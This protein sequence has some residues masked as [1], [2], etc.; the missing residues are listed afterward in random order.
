MWLRQINKI[1]AQSAVRLQRKS[2]WLAAVF[3]L[4]ASASALAAPEVD[5]P[6]RDAL[7]PAFVPGELLVKFRSEVRKQAAADY[8]EWFDISTRRTFA[9]NG[10]QHVKLPEGVGIEEALELYLEDP[11]VEHAEPNYIVY[12]DIAPP[13]DTHF[14]RLWGL[15][16]TG[17]NVDGTNGTD[18]ADIDALEAWDVTTG[19]SDII[20][21][22]V[23]SGVDINHPDLQA[24]IWANP[25][26]TP[27]NGIDDD[28]NGYIDDVSG[29]DFYIDDN[30]P[31]DASGHGTHVAG[32]IAAA[33]HNATGVTGVSWSAKIMALRFLDAWGIGTTANAIAA[34]EYATAMGADVINNSWGGG[35]YNQALKDAIDAADAVVVC[36]AG[37]S[38]ID[39]DSI[40]YYPSNY[41]SANIIAV[42]ASDQDDTLASF[43]NYGASSVDVAAPGTNIYSAAPGRETVWEDDFEDN[44]IGNWTTGGTNNTWDTTNE[45]AFAGT[46][47]LTDSP[48]VNYQINTNSWAYSPPID[49]SNHTAA[50][51]EFKMY[52]HAELGYDVLWVEASTNAVIWNAVNLQLPGD[53]NLYIGITGAVGSWASI[54]ADLEAYDDNNSVYVRFRLESDNTIN[55][56]GY[57]IDDVKVTAASSSYNGDEYTFK[58]GTSMATPHVAGLAALL[59]AHNPA[60]SIIQIKAAIEDSV[61]YKAALNNR[62]KADGRINAAAALAAPQ[63]SNVQVSTVSE[64]TAVITWTTDKP[65]DS[66][67]RYGTTSAA[68]GSYGNTATDA[69]LKTSHSITLSGLSQATDYY[70]RVGST[71]AY[72]NG[73]DNKTG[74]SNPTAED[75]F[76]TLDPDP[77]SIV[78]F[79]VINFA[80]DTITITYDEQNMQGAD[81]EDNYSFSPSMNF[82]SINPTDDDIADLGNSVFRLSMASIPA[83]QIFTLAVSNITDLAGNP[84][85]PAGIKIND[86]DNDSMA[87]DWESE[88]SLNKSINDSAADPD[89]DGYTNFQ[90][91]KARTNPRSAA[92][93]PFIIQDT[94]PNHNAG[95]T[96]T[97]RVPNN[98]DFAVLV[99][100]AHGIDTTDNT[101]VRFTI[102]DG[103]NTSY[104]RSLGDATVRFMKLTADPDDQVTRMWLMYDRSQEGGILTNFPYDSNV[105]IKVDCTDVMTNNMNQAAIDFNVETS[106]EH[107]DAQNSESVPDSSSVDGSDPDLGGA[108]DDGIK[109]DS[110]DLQGAKVIFDSSENQIPTLGPTDEIP[111]V[112]LTGVS[113]VAVP[114]NLQPPTVFD[115]PVKILIPCPGYADVS[116]LSVYY[117]NGSNWALASNAAGNVQPGGDG[118]MVPGSRVNHNETDPA[119]IEIQVYHFSGAQAGS[120]SGGGG[121]GG[122]GGGCFIETASHGSLIKHLLFYIVLNLAFI[123]LGIYG[124]K[125]IT[126]RK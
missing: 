5:R 17:Q 59:K 22:V 60:L 81:D 24:N 46:Y 47:S 23:D 49:L 96:D 9:I 75:M 105:N 65:G 37:N 31:R 123:G 54:I 42:A 82:I 111:P 45:E 74:D 79:P 50:K 28:G 34:I 97:Q 114:M 110:G 101:S 85:T 119:T 118:W 107:D 14:N 117:F 10:Y 53:P 67:I 57:Y 91:Y 106:D 88:N 108:L 20:V 113:G 83:Y 12:A 32:T 16:N 52:G 126:R 26:E 29:W 100:S 99:E 90:E 62:V 102:D 36:A 95:I 43:S 55:A 69:T 13:N 4:L 39:N 51:L 72:G 77:P 1:M 70:F 6:H 71:D 124:I 87:D 125:K 68:W 93:A 115:T 104:N 73:P 25:G 112:N 11:D 15:H 78:E 103:V 63:I 86:N 84:V 58:N 33:G 89:G 109:V 61:D 64:T 121:G 40:P 21:A 48:N 116:G 27:G 56:D 92:S 2:C 122:G 18:D 3:C 66:E 98:S 76:T 80:A 19:N 35:G 44:D 8:Q 120:F 7:Y 30:D 38:G 94:I 41:D